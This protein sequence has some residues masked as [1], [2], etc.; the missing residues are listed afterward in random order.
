LLKNLKFSGVY[1]DESVSVHV[2]LENP[3]DYRLEA[4]T[5]LFSVIAKS[6]SGDVLN[7][8]DAN[9]YVMDEASH[10]Y[11]TRNIPAPSVEGC[12]DGNEPAYRPDWLIVTDFKQDFLF[13]D[14]SVAFYFKPCKKIN[15][16]QLNH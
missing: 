14:L 4:S 8:K 12:N 6:N 1:N 3:A 15:I 7:P 5:L 11:N 13:Q 2:T 16:I 9:F 10:M